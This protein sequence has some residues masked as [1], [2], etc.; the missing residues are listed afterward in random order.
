MDMGP[1]YITALVA[2]LGSVKRVSAMSGTAFS[3]RVFGVGPKKGGTFPVE[4]D[5][6]YSSLLE[7]ESGCIATVM[8]SFDIWATNLPR[9]E[10]YG[11]GGSISLPDPNF[12]DGPVKV[13]AI[14]SD[15]FTDLPL[16]STFHDNLRGI[17]LSQMCK[18]IRE[19]GIHLASAD[20]AVHVLEV[21]LAIEASAKSGNTVKCETACERPDLMPWGITEVE[22]GF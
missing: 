16:L 6:H 21:L 13:K 19:D 12:F 2:A 20:L 3:E 22:F 5:T 8:F 1:Y 4:V 15:G 14:G 9:L 10:I 7:F 18:A 11:T 17:G